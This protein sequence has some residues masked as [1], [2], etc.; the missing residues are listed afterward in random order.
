MKYIYYQPKFAV[1][2]WLSAIIHQCAYVLLEPYIGNL[3]IADDNIRADWVQ[4]L[5][6]LG[7]AICIACT[8][9]IMIIIPTDR[10]LQFYFKSGEV[11]GKLLMSNDIKYIP[12]NIINCVIM[13]PQCIFYR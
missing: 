10:T 8:V 12:G 2:I 5:A 11:R 1:Y 7:D 3:S 6:I 4:I 9:S 13:T